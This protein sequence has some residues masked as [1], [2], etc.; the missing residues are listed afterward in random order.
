MSD[1]SEKLKNPILTFA[2]Y[3]TSMVFLN[4]LD[5]TEEDYLRQDNLDF[6]LRIIS[7]ASKTLNNPVTGSMAVQLAM[8]MRQRGLV[9]AA[10]EK[11][12]AHE[13]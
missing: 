8:D 12:G 13:Y 2:V 1:I 3:T 4:D 7:L 9:S 5:S 6:I 11:G 10:I